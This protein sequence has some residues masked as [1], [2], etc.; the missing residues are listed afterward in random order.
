MAE[1]EVNLKRIAKYVCCFYFA[2]PDPKASGLKVAEYAKKLHE[3][4]LAQKIRLQKELD[5]TVA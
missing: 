1:I 3:S 5:K 2:M 4:K